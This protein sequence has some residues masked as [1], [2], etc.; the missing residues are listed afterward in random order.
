MSE[1]SLIYV[2]RSLL[3]W[4]EAAAAIDDIIATS[5]A[6]NAREAI[7]GALLY[8]GANFVQILEGPEMAVRR[9]MDGIRRDPRH[10][11]VDVLDT[12]TSAPR[13]FEGWSMAY[14]GDSLYIRRHVEALLTEPQGS[15]GLTAAIRR[16]RHIMR[17]LVHTSH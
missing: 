4:D 5:L 15:D 1:F 17:E 3:S 2:S 14:I 11:Q 8:T 12:L 10:D 13:L 9:L 7:T 6:R 16:M